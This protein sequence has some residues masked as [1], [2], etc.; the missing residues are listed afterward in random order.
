LR[1]SGLGRK[2]IAPEARLIA[3]QGDAAGLEAFGGPG[4]MIIL[5]AV[6]RQAAFDPDPRQRRK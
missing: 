2:V 6:A 3:A 4:L 1:E 5:S